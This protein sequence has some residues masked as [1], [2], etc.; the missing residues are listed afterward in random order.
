[1]SRTR[2]IR[3]QAQDL[4]TAERHPLA[5]PSAAMGHPSV[6]TAH[7]RFALSAVAIKVELTFAAAHE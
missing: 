6:E 3:P 5:L 4:Q 2:K 1:M 7:P